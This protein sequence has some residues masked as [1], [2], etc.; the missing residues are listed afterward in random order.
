MLIN[1]RSF[2][3]LSPPTKIRARVNFFPSNTPQKHNCD[4]Q[5]FYS[6][7][8]HISFIFIPF[9]RIAI[10]GAK[11][12]GFSRKMRRD[13]NKCEAFSLCAHCILYILNVR[14][15]IYIFFVSPAFIP[16]GE[17]DSWNDRF[18]FFISHFLPV[19]VAFVSP[20]YLYFISGRVLFV[21]RLLASFPI[22]S[23]AGKF[24]CSIEKRREKNAAFFRRFSRKSPLNFFYIQYYIWSNWSASTL[25]INYGRWKIK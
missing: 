13:G 3:I 9:A 2:S 21:F 20:L 10:E 23:A 17:R 11:L 1:H 8:T 15:Y 22:F 18:P 25:Q 14:I 6:C 5:Q 19:R 7:H 24:V 12:S 4:S 16:S